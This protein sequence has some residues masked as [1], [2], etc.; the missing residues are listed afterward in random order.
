MIVKVTKL[1]RGTR[2]ARTGNVQDG[3][4]VYGEKLDQDGNVEKS[5]EKF[6]PTEFN[7][8]HIAK[9]EEFGEGAVVNIKNVKNNNFWNINNVSLADVVQESSSSDEPKSS[10][11][12]RVESSVAPISSNSEIKREALQKAMQVVA[13]ALQFQTNNDKAKLFTPTKV[14]V[15]L[16]SGSIV[17]TAKEFEEYLSGKEESVTTS[18]ASDLEPWENERVPSIPDDDLPF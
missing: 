14:S 17:D 6:L 13:T 8:E 9:F 10:P 16:I 4:W 2:E 15:E 3:L 12:E 5:Y 18:D 1:E 11:I 7:G